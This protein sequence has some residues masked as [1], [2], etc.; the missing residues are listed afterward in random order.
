MEPKDPDRK[1]AA[2]GGMGVAAIEI[3]LMVRPADEHYRHANVRHLFE[4]PINNGPG[5]RIGQ[6][7]KWANKYSKKRR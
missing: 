6:A 3:E 1:N 5:Y 2:I 4:K 7:T